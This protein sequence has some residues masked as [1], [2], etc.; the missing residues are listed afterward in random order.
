MTETRIGRFWLALPW[1]LIAC[2]AP[3]IAWWTFEPL[4]LT[5]DY[6]HP[7]FVDRPVAS[8]EFA[9]E[10]EIEAVKG[11]SVV[12][13]YIEYT[14]HRPYTATAHRAWVNDSM[15]WNAPD[16]ATVL[17]HDVGH[18][19]TSVAVNVPTSSPTRTFNFVQSLTVRMNFMRDEKITYPPIPLTI[20]DNKG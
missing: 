17:T 19:H 6:V 14:I 9:K 20:L 7:L 10:H 15:V 1:L 2:G 4:P 3:L 8:R 18:H 16:F 13:R 12:Y 11:G 5:V